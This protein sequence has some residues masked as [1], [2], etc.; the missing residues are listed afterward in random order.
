MQTDVAVEVQAGKGWRNDGVAADPVGVRCFQKGG[1]DDT[2]LSGEM[3]NRGKISSAVDTLTSG[4][5]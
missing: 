2:D 1:P 5:Q 4:Y 3:G